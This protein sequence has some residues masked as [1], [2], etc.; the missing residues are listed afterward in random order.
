MIYVTAYK[1]GGLIAPF[2]YSACLDS[3]LPMAI[4]FRK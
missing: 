3:L 2:I 4:A 1:R